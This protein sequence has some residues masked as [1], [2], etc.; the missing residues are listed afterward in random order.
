MNDDFDLPG[1]GGRRAGTWVTILGAVGAAAA[2][3]FLST[4]RGRRW[5]RE[6]P[7]VARNCT[8]MTRE[9]MARLRE[10]TEQVEK[11][12]GSF[13]QA[14][15]EV[16]DTLSAGEKARAGGGRNGGEHALSG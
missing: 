4:E 8:S 7:E 10:I 13:E 3:Y 12:V 6:L 14:L 5:L 1:G 2:V 9:A 16:S 11:A 15:G